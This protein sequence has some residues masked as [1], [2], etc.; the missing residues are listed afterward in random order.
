RISRRNIRITLKQL[1]TFDAAARHQSVSK[2]ALEMGLSQPAVTL[3]LQEFERTLGLSLFSREQR[4]F[5][6]NAN[7]RYVQAEVRNILRMAH[8]L[9]EI[10]ISGIQG[11]LNIGA[12]STIGEIILPEILGNFTNLHPEV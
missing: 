3:I 6:L 12:S 8:T 5:L 10:S 1:S 7:G 2:A 4:R 11:T 9:E